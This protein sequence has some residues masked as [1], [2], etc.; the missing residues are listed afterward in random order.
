M[1]SI[2]AYKIQWHADAF[3]IQGD[4]ICPMCSAK[5]VKERPDIFDNGDRSHVGMHPLVQCKHKVPDPPKETSEVVEV[6][7]EQR[8]ASLEERMAAMDSKLEQL[9][10]H[11]VRLEKTQ[12][13]M[14]DV[15]LSRLDEALL[16]VVERVL[17]GQVRP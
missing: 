8:L 6:S 14:Q 5:G 3:I 9:Q 1:F 4:F 10:E 11:L 13:D 15:I 17:N 16:R 7:S 12:T 2:A